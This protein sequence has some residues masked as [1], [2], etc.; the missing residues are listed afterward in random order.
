MTWDSVR[1]SESMP[2][3]AK[4][5]TNKT[6][7]NYALELL[8]THFPVILVL[9]R[10]RGRIQYGEGRMSQGIELIYHTLVQPCGTSR[11]L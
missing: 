9:V 8:K 3:G 2:N 7:N 6:K 4:H 10:C 5:K 1:L 11:L